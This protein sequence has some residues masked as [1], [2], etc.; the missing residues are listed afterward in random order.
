MVRKLLAGAILATALAL[1]LGACSS[2]TDKGPTYPVVGTVD[3]VKLEQSADA[4]RSTF[5]ALVTLAAEY[6][7]LPRCVTAGPRVCSDQAIVNELR[8]Y[9]HAAD[10]ATRGAQALARSPTKSPVALANAV[11]DANRAVEIFR[12]TVAKFNANAAAAK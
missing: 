1:G 8:R 11:A 6:V 9:M 3:Q 5:A 2:S 12:A 7:S 4:A 10:E